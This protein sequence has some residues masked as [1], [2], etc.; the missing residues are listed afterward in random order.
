MAIKPSTT[1]L[2]SKAGNGIAA[3]LFPFCLIESST[4]RNMAEIMK[5]I[6]QIKTI[7]ENVRIKKLR[8]YELRV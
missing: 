6:L 1:I 2:P 4:I 7:L 5:H 8:V 3:L